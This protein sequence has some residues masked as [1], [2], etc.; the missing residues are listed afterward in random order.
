MVHGT[1]GWELEHMEWDSTTGIAMLEYR[2]K[3][4]RT[5][6]RTV[7]QPTRPGHLNWAA[8]WAAPQWVLPRA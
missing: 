5:G 7:A 2:N 1:D 4:G 8:L 3:N 6:W